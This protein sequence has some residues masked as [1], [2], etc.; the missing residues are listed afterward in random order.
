M[1]FQVIGGICDIRDTIAN[2]SHNNWLM[3][4][5]SALGLIPT[6][7][8]ASKATSKVTEFIKNNKDINVVITIVAD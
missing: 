7:G 2:A 5:L 4:G 3:A 8:D 6:I 1:S